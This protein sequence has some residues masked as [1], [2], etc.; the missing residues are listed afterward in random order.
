MGGS[1]TRFVCLRQTD[2]KSLVAYSSVAHI[3]LVIGGI[4]VGSASG[5]SGCLA[6]IIAH[7]LCSSGMFCLTNIVFE[8]TS[9]RRIFLCKGLLQLIPSMALWW[10]LL[11][12]CNMAAPPSINLLSEVILIN[13]IV[14]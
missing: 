10:F 14:S 1:L 5:A 6:L 11:C 13:R 12:I 9:S 7:G 2:T 8:R 3:S 4:I